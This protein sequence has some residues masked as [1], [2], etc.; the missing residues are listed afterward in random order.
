MSTIA[1]QIAAYEAKRVANSAAMK[2]IMD[3]SGKDGATL[4]AAKQEEFDG[5]LADNEAIDA[6][7]KRLRAV[8]KDQAA[9]ARPVNGSSS[10]E[11]TASRSGGVVVK[12]Q[13]KLAPGLE[14][15]RAVKC[16]GMAKGVPSAA[17]DIAKSRYGENANV[18]RTLQQADGG[19][20]SV[21]KAEIP[22]G[23]NIS[24]NWAE[25]LV[26]TESS[27]FADFVEYL[28]PMTILGKFGTNGIP[29]LRRVPF[30]VPLITQTAPGEGYWVGEG[31]PKPL[32]NFGYSRTTLEP[33]KV[34]N[35]AVLTKEMIRDSSPSA[36]PMI[37]D[38]LA[39]A[40]RARLDTD[41]INPAKGAS[42]GV[43]PASIT[44]G[45]A[46][47]ASTGTSADAVR[48]DVRAL[49]Q[50][51][52]DANN[53]LSS[54]VWIMDSSTALALSMMVNALGQPEF[55]GLGINGGVFF[56]LPVI[57][58]EYVPTGIVVLMNAGDIYLAD[59]GGIT[60][61]MSTEA[62]LEML[63]SGLTQSAVA[64]V[65]GASLVSLWQTNSVGFLAE[66]TVNWARRRSTAVAYLTGVAW[67][68]A[69]P[70]S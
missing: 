32:T 67:G 1:E 28:R 66:R 47:V 42:A 33:L 59:E 23:A 52:V 44:N 11:A 12:S 2:S 49:M 36:E 38:E 19:I 48:V 27:A 30:R 35:I 61:D 20:L 65:N 16:L 46:T 29:A 56:G 64:D 24:G 53:P 50:K 43:S 6:H 21:Q 39:N 57:V 7:L 8:E 68:G 62:S 17:I 70:A 31:K 13:P 3:E 18:V 26:G 9:T 15:A 60:V 45:A 40:L 58:S 51:F 4:D 69:V 54:G 22:A 37:R 34:A 25:A 10:E 14:F 41:Y 5:L 55:T 63:D